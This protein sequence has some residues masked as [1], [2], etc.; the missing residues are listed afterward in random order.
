METETHVSINRHKIA[1]I[2]EETL[3]NNSAVEYGLSVQMV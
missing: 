3:L 1:A 2:V